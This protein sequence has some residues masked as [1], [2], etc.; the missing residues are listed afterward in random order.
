M[1]GGR[2]QRQG[3]VVSS[4]S[5][6]WRRS[7]RGRSETLAM[8]SALVNI[9]SIVQQDLKCFTRSSTFQT[10]RLRL[11]IFWSGVYENGCTVLAARL[12]SGASMFSTFGGT[13]RAPPSPRAAFAPRSAPDDDS[14]DKPLASD[15]TARMCGSGM[16]SAKRQLHNSFLVGTC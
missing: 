10:L 6:S 11:Y 3:R 8:T 13:F 4:A 12:V 16:E 5:R 2:L 7:Q 14:N 9:I 15:Q 1:W